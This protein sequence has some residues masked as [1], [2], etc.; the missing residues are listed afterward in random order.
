MR[1]TLLLLI[2]FSAFISC[3]KETTE[4]RDSLVGN[5]AWNFSYDTNGTQM[6]SIDSNI[7]HQMAFI[8]DGRFYSD[9]YCMN[10]APAEG[11]FDIKVSGSEKVLVLT[12]KS[13]QPVKYKF[14]LNDNRLIV[15]E[16]NNNVT[17]YH[18][19]SRE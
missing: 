12:S 6:K 2:M 4:L 15:I 14:K 10:G 5:W 13:L 16:T 1:Y 17:W 3:K 19:F 9:V 11:T 7:V 18:D 8:N